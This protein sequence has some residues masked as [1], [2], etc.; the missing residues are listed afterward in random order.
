MCVPVT[1]LEPSCTHPLPESGG[2]RG[3]HRTRKGAGIIQPPAT[4]LLPRTEGP[5]AWG[6]A[7]CPLRAAGAGALPLAKPSGVEQ[8][9]AR[10]QPRALPRSV[11]S[12][13]SAARPQG[14]GQQVGV[15]ASFGGCVACG[16]PS[17]RLQRPLWSSIRCQELGSLRSGIMLAAPS[18]A[19]RAP[20]LPRPPTEGGSSGDPAVEPFGVAAPL[21]AVAKKTRDVIVLTIHWHRH[22]RLPAGSPS[23]RAP[24]GSGAGSGAGPVPR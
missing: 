16:C 9:R 13:G 6:V 2:V 3:V 23:A 15:G 18:A 22:L 7:R 17:P 19:G 12:H 8:R 4:V 21:Q 20:C 10:L 5:R 24:G 14:G 1:W 11:G